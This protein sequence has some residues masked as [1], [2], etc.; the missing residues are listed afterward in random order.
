MSRHIEVSSMC[1]SHLTLVFFSD[2]AVG[3]VEFEAPLSHSNVC[4]GKTGKVHCDEIDTIFE[5]I[6][7]TDLI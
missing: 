3:N 6:I 7:L 2:S 5:R 1:K 4:S